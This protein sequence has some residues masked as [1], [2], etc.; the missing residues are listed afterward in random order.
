[1]LAF[2]PISTECGCGV[3]PVPESGI[4]IIAAPLLES[5]RLPEAVPGA[6][7][8]NTTGRLTL[9]AGL[10]V[11]GVVAPVLKPEPLMLSCVMVAAAFPVFE[12]FT[13][14]VTGVFRTSDPKP[15]LLGVAVR[16]AEFGVAV[17]VGVGLGFCPG[18]PLALCPPPPPAHPIMLKQ[19]KTDRKTKRQSLLA[20]LLLRNGDS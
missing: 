20:N 19:A 5:V 16:T 6:L 11:M 9:C 8:E 4:E 13:V 17:G 1:V 18:E 10:S 12:I 14:S 3:S 2:Q 7:G 15:R